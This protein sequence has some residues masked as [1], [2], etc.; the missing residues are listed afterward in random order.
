MGTREG[1]MPVTDFFTEVTD[2]FA[3]LVA[4]KLPHDV[5]VIQE[6]TMRHMRTKLLGMREFFV[7]RLM[8][9]F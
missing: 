7:G 2:F 1:R 3:K 5:K 9:V 4:L 8:K 6:V